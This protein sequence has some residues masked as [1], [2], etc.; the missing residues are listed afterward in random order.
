MKNQKK[1]FNRFSIRVFYLLTFVCFSMIS[2]TEERELPIYSSCIVFTPDIQQSSPYMS[3]SSADSLSRTAIPLQISNKN[4]LYLHT[5]Y[6]DN[7]VASFSTS[8]IDG[9]PVTR[10]IPINIESMCTSFGVSAYSYTGSWDGGQIPDFMYDIPM[11]N[12]GNVWSSSSA[13]YWP[14]EA[15]KIR[16]F[17]Y[18]PNGNASY[19]L[20]DRTVAGAPTL[21]CTVPHDVPEQQDLLV[22]GSGELAGNSGTTVN[23]TFH[24]A[25]TAVRFVC[26][27]DMRAGT[28]KSVTLKNVY[29]SATYNLETGEWSDRGTQ[30]SFLQ[31]FDR[32]TSGMANEMITSEP[33]TFMMI[34]QIFPDNGC[35]SAQSYDAAVCVQTGTVTEMAYIELLLC[36][37]LTKSDE[38]F[39]GQITPISYIC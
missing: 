19:R 38:L 17:A 39:L 16:F 3:R 9:T 22:A 25:L 31:E 28:V 23:L 13:Y 36:C 21:T 29:S 18:A 26:G 20:S 12:S 4:N 37:F 24:H 5:I 30:A 33:Q 32:E 6:S 35:A 1:L 11:I 7:I 10:S 34:P 27:D 15:Y 2:Y 14:G 8:Q